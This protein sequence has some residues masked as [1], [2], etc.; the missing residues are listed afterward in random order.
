MEYVFGEEIKLMNFT[1]F[2]LMNDGSIENYCH[3]IKSRS[4][5]SQTRARTRFLSSIQPR[6]HKQALEPHVSSG[7]KT[8][9]SLAV[10]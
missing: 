2:H 6:Q 9:D 3:N 8:A 4:H 7:S 1:I 5:G 10:L